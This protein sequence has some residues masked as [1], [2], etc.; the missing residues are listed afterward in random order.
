MFIQLARAVAPLIGQSFDMSPLVDIRS[1]GL[2]VV[3]QTGFET[4]LSGEIER[5]GRRMKVELCFNRTFGVG[6]G[7]IASWTRPMRP[8]YS[9][10][11]RS[12][13]GES[14]GFE[15][16]VLHFD[17]KYRVEFVEE[18][19]GVADDAVGD[20]SS[21]QGEK[22]GGALRSDLLKM[23]AYRDA[24][25]QTAGAYIL[26]PGGDA[27][28][29][30]SPFTQYQELLPGLGAFV[31]R[32][33]DSGA[34]CGALTLQRFLNDVFDHLATR[35]TRHE[36]SRYWLDEV[37]GKPS[38][39]IQSGQG[40]GLPADTK[41]LLGIAESR[42]HWTWIKQRNTFNVNAGLS[43]HES[44]FDFGLAQSQFLLLFCPTSEEFALARI[45][46]SPEALSS[47]SMMATEYPG[48]LGAVYWC[49]QV[50]WVQRPD[51]LVGISPSSI[52]HAVHSIGA[53][54]QS[55]CTLPW[56]SLQANNE[57]I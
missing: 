57:L 3:L 12:A 25:R 31:L 24:I 21:I 23:H 39:S 5:H 43:T 22:R 37:Y 15:P 52:R 41:V 26:Y 34:P 40:E 14:A 27:E 28:V 50:S 44:S 32:P 49:V 48:P 18:L 33:T 10:I 4:V 51:W 9:L 19:F 2:N 1:D 30:R 29:E 35:F 54:H 46:S 55:L 47:M 17:A 16:V 6:P 11:V 36:R 13:D 42:Q 53:S 8:D 56:G 7:R 38:L 45:V 20:G